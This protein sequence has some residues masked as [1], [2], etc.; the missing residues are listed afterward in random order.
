MTP[1]SIEAQAHTTSTPIDRP[2]ATTPLV[3]LA[4]LVFVCSVAALVILEIAERPTLTL[5]ALV[6]PVITGL[7]VSGHVCTV[8]R[9]QNVAIDKIERQ[10]NGVLDERIRTQVLS[11]LAEAAPL[12]VVPA[13]ETDV[14]FTTPAGAAGAEGPSS[15]TLPSG[16]VPLA[17]DEH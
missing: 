5:V 13:H 14:A 1:P 10:T 6:T 8:T 16:F 15:A 17:G 11:A 2:A 12:P 4:A 9:Q 7:L 3:V